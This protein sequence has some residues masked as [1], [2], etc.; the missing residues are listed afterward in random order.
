[1][2][3][4]TLAMAQVSDGVFRNARLEGSGLRDDAL[5]IDAMAG[6]SSVCGQ[7]APAVCTFTAKGQPCS[8]PAGWSAGR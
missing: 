5:I 4:D 8:R 2:V 1:M 3:L 7:P 6:L